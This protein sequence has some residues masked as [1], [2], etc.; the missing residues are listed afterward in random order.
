MEQIHA[1]TYAAVAVA[2]EL[3]ELTEKEVAALRLRLV[4]GGDPRNSYGYEKVK[5]LFTEQGGTA[6]H[7]EA[8]RAFL[9]ITAQQPAA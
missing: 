2:I 1:G 7:D 6:M 4:L 3:A 8:K 9:A 5:H